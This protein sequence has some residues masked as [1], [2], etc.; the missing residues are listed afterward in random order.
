MLTAA[1][2]DIAAATEV[3][4]ACPVTVKTAAPVRRI[5]APGF[6]DEVPPVTFP[7]ILILPAPVIPYVMPPV[8]PVPPFTLPVIFIIGKPPVMLIP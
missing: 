3:A 1:V 5:P 6:V 4:F 8:P 2:D 7:V